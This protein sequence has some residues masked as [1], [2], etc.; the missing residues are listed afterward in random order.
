MGFDSGLREQVD[1]LSP[2]LSAIGETR[3][4]GNM[5]IKQ[6]SGLALVLVVSL[7]LFLA[8]NQLHTTLTQALE[9]KYSEGIKNEGWD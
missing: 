8:F 5:T 2:S 4:R 6:A 7:L 3:E 1:N 9:R